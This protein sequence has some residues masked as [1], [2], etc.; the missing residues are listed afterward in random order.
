MKLEYGKQYVRRDGEVTGLLG[1]HTNRDFPYKDPTTGETYTKNGEFDILDEGEVCGLDLVREY[2]TPTPIQAGVLEVP[3]TTEQAKSE[4]T[5]PTLSA[6]QI[7]HGGT[8]YKSC[9]IQ[10]WDYI[11]RNNIPFLEGSA[12]KYIS[13]WRDKG[14]IEDLRKA[15]HFIEKVIELEEEPK[16][17]VP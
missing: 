8:H 12:I 17:A 7:Q 1:K 10:P 5:V 4:V 13:R 11:A 16:E 3:T 2:E 9:I 15:I 14:G 6:N